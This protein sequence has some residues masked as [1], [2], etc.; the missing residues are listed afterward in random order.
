MGQTLSFLQKSNFLSVEY[1]IPCLVCFSREDDPC[2]VKC[3]EQGDSRRTV[4]LVPCSRGNLSERP[5]DK[6]FMRT[7]G[8]HQRISHTHLGLRFLRCRI[9]ECELGTSNI[10]SARSKK[11]TIKFYN[12]ALFRSFAR[13]HE[14]RNA[15]N[16]LSHGQRRSLG[17]RHLYLSV[18]L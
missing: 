8:Y 14:M 12:S 13:G 10:E 16:L 1:L 2:R 18:H 3:V 9:E 4:F 5:W 6:G 15:Q 7:E 17:T 11:K